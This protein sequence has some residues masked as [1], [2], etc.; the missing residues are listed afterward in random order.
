MVRV[1]IAASR[2]VVRATGCGVVWKRQRGKKRK[3]TDHVGSVSQ[4]RKKEKESSAVDLLW[5]FLT[6]SL[7]VG[8]LVWHLC[9]LTSVRF[10][11]RVSR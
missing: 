6:V 2:I 11:G 1:V 7:R 5:V 10:F 3:E 9:E 4:K 8:S